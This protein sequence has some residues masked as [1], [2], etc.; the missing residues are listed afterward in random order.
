MLLPVTS[1]EEQWNRIKSNQ[2]TGLLIIRQPD[3]NT[4]LESIYDVALVFLYTY[5]LNEYLKARRQQGLSET[6]YK[7]IRST[8][9]F[10]PDLPIY[11]DL[12]NIIPRYIDILRSAVKFRVSRES[13]SALI[14]YIEKNRI[15]LFL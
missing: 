10:D 13:N 3:C 7:Y 12:S 1:G 4:P 15:S 2:V 8:D 6:V 5:I 14:I 11:R 9:I